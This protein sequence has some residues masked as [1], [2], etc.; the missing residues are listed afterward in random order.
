MTRSGAESSVVVSALTVGALYG[1]RKLSE[2]AVSAGTP[3]ARSRKSSAA[4]RA[5]GGGSPP[6]AV[7][8][9]AVGYCFT[10]FVLAL[11]A[12]GVPD[13]AGAMALL[14]MVSAILVQGSAV[15]TDISEATA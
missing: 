13:L 8:T 11:V 2:P 15:F 1:Y 3:A 9:F 5:L 10:Y 7:H 14:I 12:V 4:A 6:V